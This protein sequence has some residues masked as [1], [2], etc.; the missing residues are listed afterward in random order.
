VTTCRRTVK[1]LS[2]IELKFSLPWPVQIILTPSTVSSVCTVSLL[3][4]LI[5]RVVSW[6]CSLPHRPSEIY[7][8]ITKCYTRIFTFL[9]QIRR[10]SH[11]LSRRRL[12]LDESSSTSLD[13][14]ALYY[15][16]RTRI[17][18]F[19]QSLYYYIS[20]LVLEPC[21]QKLR[22]DLRDAEDVDAMIEIHASYI[23]N[24]I[25][26]S[27]LGTRLELIHKTILKVLDLGIK[28]R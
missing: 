17:L 26:Q 5:L 14:R 1:A 27:L 2:I 22:K 16:L 4:S 25:D 11:I 23:K 15:S 20:T 9:L 21:L 19:N 6:D 8:N 3:I 13:E 24:V 12:I 28:V 18:W 7:A 10:S